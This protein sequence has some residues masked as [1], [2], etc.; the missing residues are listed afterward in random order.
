MGKGVPASGPPRALALASGLHYA[1]G[2][3]QK[4]FTS[5]KPLFK[6]RHFGGIC[7]I[8]PLFHHMYSR[9]GEGETCTPS[10]NLPTI[11]ATLS[12]NCGM[13]LLLSETLLLLL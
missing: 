1:G 9:K 2:R 7:G 4:T 13:K 8:S 10:P 3:F 12:L 11:L 5:A 6:N